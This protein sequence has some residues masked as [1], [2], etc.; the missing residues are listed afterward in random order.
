MLLQLQVT[1]AQGNP[2]SGIRLTS[3]LTIIYHYQPGELEA[4]H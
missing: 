4:F 3:P 1:D 2:V